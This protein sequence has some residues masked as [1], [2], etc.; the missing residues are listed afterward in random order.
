MADIE[1]REQDENRILGAAAPAIM[2]LLKRRRES[3]VMK[4][5]GEYRNGNTSLMNTIS[6]IATL[7]GML[8]DVR[9][10]LED[11]NKGR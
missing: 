4:L 11:H 2:G 10:R 7:E 9:A 5:I 6:E 1:L 3:A 8:A